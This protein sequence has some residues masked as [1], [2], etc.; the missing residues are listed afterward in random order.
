MIFSYFPLKDLSHQ[1]I[2]FLKQMIV[3]CFYNRRMKTVVQNILR[4]A[5]ERVLEET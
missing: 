5:A 2:Y 3:A 1:P 4:Y